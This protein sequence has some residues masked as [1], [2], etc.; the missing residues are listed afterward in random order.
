MKKM[1]VVLMIIVIATIAFSSANA[2]F[3]EFMDKMDER[4]LVWL[5][6]YN[7]DDE[8]DGIPVFKDAT[9]YLYD[10]SAHIAPEYDDSKIWIVETNIRNFLIDG[11]VYNPQVW[12]YEAGGNVIETI[13][14]CNE[15]LSKLF[16]EEYKNEKFHKICILTWWH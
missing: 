2:G 6:A 8:Y 14:D 1:L 9:M 15:N 7:L 10:T 4:Y 12:I 13:I 16:G 11:G 5:Q 3:N